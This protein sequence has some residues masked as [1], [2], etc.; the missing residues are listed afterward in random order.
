M[1]R[2][3]LILAA[4]T[5]FDLGVMTVGAQAQQN[6]PT[7][8]STGTAS[9]SPGQGGTGA[10]L[11]TFEDLATRHEGRG[12]ASQTGW[13]ISGDIKL[14]KTVH[15]KIDAVNT[16][17]ACLAKRGEVVTHEGAQQ[18]RLP[19]AGTGPLSEIPGRKN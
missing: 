19:D 11:K 3:A 2:T 13:D 10:G 7:T 17:R 6:A 5:A 12:A 1:R 18:C 4:A 14:L 15:I 16:V 8:R 9:S